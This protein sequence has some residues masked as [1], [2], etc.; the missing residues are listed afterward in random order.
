[1]FIFKQLKE[2]LSDT[3]HFLLSGF[4][5]KLKNPKEK[6]TVVM[7]VLPE[8]YGIMEYSLRFLT[9]C[10]LDNCNEIIIVS[11]SKK[12]YSENVSITKLF[13][14]KVKI[15]YVVLPLYKR[16]LL[17]LNFSG[18]VIHATNLVTSIKHSRSKY[19]FMHDMDCFILEKNYLE[20]LFS[21][22]RNEK[23]NLI[24]TYT[25]SYP[26]GEFPA[27]YELMVSREFL[28]KTPP[29][30]IYARTIYGEYYSTFTRCYLRSKCGRE[31]LGN[32]DVGVH[33]KHLFV[34]FRTFQEQ[35]SDFIDSKYSIFLLFVLSL[36][37]PFVKHNLFKSLD[38]YFNN[39]ILEKTPYLEELEMDYYRVSK[40]PLISQREKEIMYS[41]F[42][43]LKE[44]LI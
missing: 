14:N 7:P 1:M 42:S 6:Y 32:I 34:N 5:N 9:S 11:D 19:I 30:M 31:K 24:S 20:D 8:F 22:I 41:S 23:L 36:A 37:N 25:R 35:K 39:A 26:Y 43:R 21:Q 13:L 40:S 27:L 15:K 33:F 10:N 12:Y 4:W 3:H 29:F 44:K 38:E 17:K 18:Y 16:L 2:F 28:T